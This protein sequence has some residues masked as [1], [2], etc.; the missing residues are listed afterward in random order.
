MFIICESCGKDNHGNKYEHD[1]FWQLEGLTCV[2]I[3][4]NRQQSVISKTSKYSIVI[5]GVATGGGGASG[6]VAPQP[7]SDPIFRFVQIR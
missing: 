4:S 3:K 1:S 5:S 7:F 6:A 2:A